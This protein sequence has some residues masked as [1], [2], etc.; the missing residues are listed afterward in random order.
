VFT[1]G[2]GTVGAAAVGAAAVGAA[3]LGAAAVGA[4]TLGAAAAGGATLGA[5]TRG[6]AGGASDAV[7]AEDAGA[8]VVAAAG[9]PVEPLGAVTFDTGTGTSAAPPSAGFAKKATAAANPATTGISLCKKPRSELK[10]ILEVWPE[11]GN[12]YT[13]PNELHE[14]P[15]RLSGRESSAGAGSEKLQGGMRAHSAARSLAARTARTILPAHA[16][17]FHLGSRGRLGNQLFQ[18]AGTIGLAAS[19]DAKAVFLED[20]EYRRHFSLPDEFFAGRITVARAHQS[21]PHAV[22]IDEKARVYLQDLSLWTRCRAA[23]HRWLQPSERAREIAVE[24]HSDL[25]ALPCKT[26]LHVRRGDFLTNPA[27]KPCP[28]AYYEH[29]VALTLAEHPST[30]FLVFS[31]DIDWCR[32][33]LGIPRAHYVSDN[34]DWLDLTLMSQCEHHI[35]ANSTFSWWGAF[36]ST[37]PSPI[38]PWLTGVSWPLR[39]RQ[40]GGWREI[41]VMPDS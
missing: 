12:P 32:E 29:G 38:V 31:D 41:E 8:W 13:I 14:S 35:C 4:A 21:W 15:G 10:L 25:L 1:V 23:I 27:H 9:A 5:S 26:A 20:W 7:P 2:A 11:R 34:P 39:M 6:A 19:L 33:N 17:T 16:L 36:L 22:A 3:T 28:I 40:P 37:D 24:R 30:E 18:V